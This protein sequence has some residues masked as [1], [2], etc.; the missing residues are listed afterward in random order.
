MSFSFREVLEEF[1]SVSA[2]WSRNDHAVFLDRPSENLHQ[3]LESIRQAYRVRNAEHGL[4]RSCCRP[5]VDG[6]KV[7]AHHRELNRQRMQR[8]RSREAA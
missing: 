4:C 5:R 7:C 2:C 3:P 6:L 8:L 1:V